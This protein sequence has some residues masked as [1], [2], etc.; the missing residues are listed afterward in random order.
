MLYHL[1]YPFHTQ[2]SVLNVA[3]YIT[4]RTAAATLSALAP[5][6]SV[7]GSSQAA[8]VSIGQVIRAE[9]PRSH[10]QGST[11][12]MGVADSD[13]GAGARRCCQ[14]ISRM[15]LSD[16]G[17]DN[18]RVQAIRV[19]YY[20]KIVGQSHHGLLPRYRW[21]CRSWSASQS[22]S[23]CSSSS[24]KVL[25]RASSFR[26]SSGS[27]RIYGTAI[28]SSR[29]SSWSRVERREPHRRPGRPRDQCSPL[30]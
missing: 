25:P 20:L 11:P 7:R 26:S 18:D 28:W 30:P 5:A 15:S 22:A 6:R 12:T 17:A 3:R 8:R 9:G 14:Q 2:L 24:T 16:R 19:R 21:G 29:C 23:C 1:L 10:R 4:F 27:F 13:G